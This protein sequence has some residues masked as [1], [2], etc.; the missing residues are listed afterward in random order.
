[1][2]IKTDLSRRRINEL[3][4]KIIVKSGEQRIK[5]EEKES[6]EK[7]GR[8]LDTNICRVG[9]RE[10]R[11]RKKYLQKQWL[12]TSQIYWQTIASVNIQNAQ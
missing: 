6:S 11:K 7:R 8:L 4:D 1:M 10:R 9:I 2:A 5:S 3:E 12:K